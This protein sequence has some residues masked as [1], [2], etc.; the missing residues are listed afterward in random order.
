MLNA[1]INLSPNMNLKIHFLK[2]HYNVDSKKL[3]D[4]NEEQ[5]ESFL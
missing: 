3:S 5:A 4:N 2:S 1:Y